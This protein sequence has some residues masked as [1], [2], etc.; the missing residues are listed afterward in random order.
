M[1]K[2]LVGLLTAIIAVSCV[3]CLT[4]C[5]DTVKNGSKIRTLKME[6]E[7]YDAAGTVTATTDVYMELYLN[8]APKSTEHITKLVKD[9]YYNGTAISNINT[10]WLEFGAYAYAEDG[11]LSKKEYNNG[12]VEG[13]FLNNGLQ[14]NRLTTAKGAIIFKR[15][16]DDNSSDTA[17]SKYNTAENTMVI[18]FSSSAST[19]FPANSYC[20]LGMVRSDDANQDADTELE[21]KSSID[22]LSSLTE[23]TETEVDDN[24]VTTYFYEKTGTYYTKWT[25]EDSNV[26]YAEGAEVDSDNELTGAELEEFNT[27]FGENKNYFLVVP[28]VKLIIKSVTV[29]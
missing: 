21:K 22:K 15:D 29:C 7:V 24:K 27:L 16:Y 8:F 10:N 13:E 1:K 12:K 26:H 20:I 3:F 19:T 11:T 2:L 14:G 18:C 28:C 5:G 25:D 4:A 6:L 23:Y 17:E 9:G